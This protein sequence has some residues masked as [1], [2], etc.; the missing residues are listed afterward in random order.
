MGCG[1]SSNTAVTPLTPEEVKRD[2]DETG[3]RRGDSAVSKVTTDSGVV[4]DLPGALP[5]KQPPLM[6]VGEGLLQQEGAAQEHKTSN[7]ILEELFLQGIIPAGQHR[8]SRAGEAYCIMLNENEGVMRTPPARLESLKT[9]KA[10]NLPSREEIEE[11]L[12]LADERRKSEENELKMR[13][14][15]K[16]A[17]GVRSPAPFC[18]PN[19]DADLT[20]VETLLSPLTQDTSSSP[21]HSLIPRE[22]A[23]GG[24][25]VRE[26]AIDGRESKEDVSRGERR[27]KKGD[28]NGSVDKRDVFKSRE[29]NGDGEEGGEDEEE[30][31]QV[32]ELKEDEIRT[33]SRELEFDSRFKFISI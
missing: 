21:T 6:C 24:E 31:T 29:E 15:S 33:A 12:R 23:E 11:K 16:S 18:T 14:R 22:A 3:S 2:E 13:L 20:P 27:D 28:G 1:S 9:K 30:L 8:E 25:C 5:K 19:E 7:E 26:A 4:M 32:E 17:H 10:E